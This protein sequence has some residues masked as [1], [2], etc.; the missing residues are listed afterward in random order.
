MLSTFDFWF[1]KKICKTSENKREKTNNT[2]NEITEKH[3]VRKTKNKIS[4]IPIVSLINCR[5]KISLV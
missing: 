2:K 1:F 4:P 3:K 5:F